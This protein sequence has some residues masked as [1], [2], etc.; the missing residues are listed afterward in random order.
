[1][2]VIAGTA[3]NENCPR[4]SLSALALKFAHLI[5]M[6]APRMT[7]PVGSLTTPCTRRLSAPKDE[8]TNIPKDNPSIAIVSVR[9]MLAWTVGEHTGGLFRTQ[10]SEAQFFAGWQRAPRLGRGVLH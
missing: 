6:T 10:T 2:P 1:M 9:R 8:D 3:A 7:A 5:I 4:S